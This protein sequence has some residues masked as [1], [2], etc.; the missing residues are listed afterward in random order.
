VS[1]KDVILRATEEFGSFHEFSS[2]LGGDICESFKVKTSTR[3]FF[4]KVIN[5]D[6]YPILEA[7]KKNL[8]ILNTGFKHIPNTISLGKHERTAYLLLEYIESGQSSTEI[9]LEFG[10]NLAGLHKVKSEAFGLG[11]DNYIGTIRQNNDWNSSG[12]SFFITSRLQPLLAQAKAKNLLNNSDLKRFESLIRKLDNILMKEPPSLIHGD[13]WSGNYLIGKSDIYIFDPA[14]YYGF[15]ESDIAMTRLFGGF[16]T[17]FYEG[18]KE[19]YPLE[20]GWEDRCLILN[21][22]PLLVHLILFGRSYYG[23]INQ[24]LNKF[25]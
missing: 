18:Y 22:Y 20:N 16:D 25:V 10:R 15:R 3:A 5:D 19:V 21:L 12:V 6:A 7:E 17:S 13:L 23:Q 11:Y 14:C 24:I 8:D 9:S 1:I 2:V 4:I